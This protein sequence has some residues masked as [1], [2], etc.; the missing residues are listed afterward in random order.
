MPIG[1]LSDLYD[2]WL[3]QEGI[4]DLIDKRDKEFFPGGMI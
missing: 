3:A 2:F 1:E 4:V